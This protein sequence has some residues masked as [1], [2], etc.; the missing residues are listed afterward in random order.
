MLEA[1]DVDAEV[2]DERL[3]VA[4]GAGAGLSQRRRVEGYANRS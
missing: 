2:V 3:D 1:L 4:R